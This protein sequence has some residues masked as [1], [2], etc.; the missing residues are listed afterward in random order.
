MTRGSTTRDEAAWDP[1]DDDL[2][3]RSHVEPEADGTVEVRG[4][5]AAWNRSRA[6]AADAV[7]SCPSR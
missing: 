7:A 5:W 2:G 4:R 1:Y 6:A 3:G